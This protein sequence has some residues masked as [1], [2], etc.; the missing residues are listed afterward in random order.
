MSTTADTFTLDELL[1]ALA[2]AAVEADGEPAGIRMVDLCE[3]TGRSSV[4]L[5]RDL[6]R[7]I[8]AG[9]VECVRIWMTRIDGTRIRVPGYR[10]RHEHGGTGG[11]AEGV[12]AVGES[13]LGEKHQAGAGGERGVPGPG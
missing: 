12:P 1:L 7:L 3:V 5:A 11:A 10:V 8:A 2:G 4:G 13:V 9:K 6:Q